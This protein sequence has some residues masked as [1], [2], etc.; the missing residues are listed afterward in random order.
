MAQAK[1]QFL[2][3]ENGEK[4][5]VILPIQEYEALMEAIQDLAI[6]A[7]QRDVPR[8]PI[9]GVKERLGR[10][11]V[12]RV[13]AIIEKLPPDEQDAVSE[14]IAAEL[15]DDADWDARFDA[16]TEEQWD[17]MEEMVRRD[18]S[19]RGNA[20]IE[21]ALPRNEYTAV[22]KQDCDWWIGWI[23]EVPG[24]NCQ[25][26][27]RDELLDTLRITLKEILEINKAESIAFAGGDF[28]TERIL[29]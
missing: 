20:P 6:I 1:E 23:E 11:A 9:G 18:V 17:K 4:T 29:I 15:M 14:R 2:V 7:E 5:A 3:D 12:R 21:N 25:E 19:A 22:I 10:K 28:Q 16:T 13:V 24:V 27:T 8:M 26:A